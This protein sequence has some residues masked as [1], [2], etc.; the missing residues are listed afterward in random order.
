M[1]NIDKEMES[2]TNTLKSKLELRARVVQ[3][4][5]QRDKEMGNIKEI[6]I[7]SR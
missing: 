1:K 7:Y 3:N 2:S 5:T 6:Q 4:V